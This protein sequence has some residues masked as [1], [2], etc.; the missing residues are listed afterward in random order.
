MAGRILIQIAIETYTK[1]CGLQ[2]NGSCY[3]Y[4]LLLQGAVAKQAAE[5][6]NICRNR[7]HSTV[8][9]VQRTV[10]LKQFVA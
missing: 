2:R 10:I 1:V 3:I 6:R 5:P 9:K 7:I 4:S 8:I